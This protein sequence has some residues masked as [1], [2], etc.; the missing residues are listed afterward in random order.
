MA[1]FAPHPSTLGALFVA[2]GT[3]LVAGYLFM[4]HPATVYRLRNPFEGDP[5][6]V[7]GTLTASYQAVGFFFAV[8]GTVAWTLLVLGKTTLPPPGA[9]G[10]GVVTTAVGLGLTRTTTRARQRAG[11]AGVV[12]GLGVLAGGLAVSGLF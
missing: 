8:A 3:C 9:V 6:T 7:D 2:G 4:A 1:Q 12:V 5:E 11:I 10:T